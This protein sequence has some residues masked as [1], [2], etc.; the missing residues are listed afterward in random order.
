MEITINFTESSVIHA[1]LDT[2]IVKA[3]SSVKNGGEARFPEPASYFFASLAL[4]AGYY[5]QS[6]CNARE[7]STHGITITQGSKSS[8]GANRF[9]QDIGIAI[10]LPEDF[11]AKYRAPL[12]AAVSGCTVKKMIEAAPQFTVTVN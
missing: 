11:P 5:L 1:N 4:C 12:A 7:I 10:N 8:S 6:F 9:Q 2:F 3:D